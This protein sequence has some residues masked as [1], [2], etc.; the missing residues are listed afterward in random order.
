[1]IMPVAGRRHVP[2]SEHE[3]P[4]VL[5]CS[6]SY[7]VQYDLQAYDKACGTIFES[8]PGRHEGEKLQSV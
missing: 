6:I 8:P 1:M 5:G 7:Y 4:N 2:K 3:P